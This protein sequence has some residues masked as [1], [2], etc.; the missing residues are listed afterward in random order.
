MKKIIRISVIL[1]LAVCMLA[2]CGCDGSQRKLVFVNHNLQGTAT[3][4]FGTEEASEG[5]H[6]TGTVYVQKEENEATA[7]ITAHLKRGESHGEGASF[8][9]EKGWIVTG[10]LSDFPNTNSLSDRF[11]AANIVKTADSGSDWAYIVEVGCNRNLDIPDG[12]EGDVIIN[13][14]WDYMSS[15]PKE[16]T[17]LAGVGSGY[18]GGTNANG[19]DSVITT[20]PL[21]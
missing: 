18:A 1:L 16:F 2:L 20:I 8:Y 6:A 5:M 15:G 9:V 10:V 19:I 7:T 17:L 4:A 11:D 21:S 13:L 12:A 14:K 3:F